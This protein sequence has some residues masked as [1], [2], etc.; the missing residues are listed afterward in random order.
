MPR[1]ATG[2]LRPLANGWEARIRIEG[3]TRK[4]FALLASLS[5]E[6][7]AHRCRAMA[8]M[9]QRLRATGHVADAHE[10]LTIAARVR[11]GKDWDAVITAVDALCGGKAPLIAK[12]ATITFGELA[13]EWTSGKLHAKYPDHVEWKQTSDLD[14]MRLK[15][16]VYPVLEHVPLH[17]VTIAHAQEVMRGIPS[18]KSKATR[19]HVGQLMARTLN[20]AVYPCEY[21]ATTPL[22]K[23]FLPRLGKGKALAYLYPDEDRKLMAC[24]ATDDRP[25]VPFVSRLFYGFMA[26]EGLRSS[27]GQALRWKHVDLV[28]GS[29]RVDVNKTDDPR[30]WALDPCVVKAL[31]AWKDEHPDDEPG[32]LIFRDLE[33]PH[34]MA[35]MFR[36]HLKLAGVTRAELFERSDVRRPIRAHDLRATFVTVNLANGKTEAWIADRT[37]HTTSAMLNRYRRSA[38]AHSELGQGELTPLNEALATPHLCPGDVLSGGVTGHVVSENVEQCTIPAAYRLPIEHSS[39]C[40][41]TRDRRQER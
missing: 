16:W 23:G 13:N 38:R 39:A 6:D 21:I 40:D 20:M 4:G 19:R 34:H 35:S 14:E 1:P 37:G 10:L 8:S 9:A 5:D 22:P 29:I 7:A 3:K 31:Q 15:K 11:P 25:G 2:E 33:Q 24:V 18:T 12:G 27:E 36:Q 30:T 26:R 41:R 17:A 28:R 32:D